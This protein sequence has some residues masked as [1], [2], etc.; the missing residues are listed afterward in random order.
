M[1]YIKKENRLQSGAN[2]LFIIIIIIIIIIWIM[3]PSKY[4]RMHP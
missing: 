2:L 1:F 3:H 4:Q